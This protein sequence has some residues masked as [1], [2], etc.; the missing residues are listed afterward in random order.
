MCGIYFNSS[1][2]DRGIVE[3]K[4]KSIIYRG[5]DHM[6]IQNL[7]GMTF[8]HL[9]LAILD[10]DS[11]SNQPME[12]QGLHI[13]FNGEIYNFLEIKD[14][15]VAKGYE[16][17]T[18]SDTEVLLAAYKEWGSEMLQ[19]INGMFAF[20]IYDIENNKLFCA[21]DR[22][23]VKPVYYRL[24]DDILEICSQLRPMLLDKK[25]KVNEEAVSI[26]LDCRYIPSPYT[27]I[28]GFYKLASRKFFGVRH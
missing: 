8:G 18:T 9:R 22:L 19:H 5:P 21:R 20:V 26:Y 4:L 16:F 23:G 17:R 28:D 27:I 10:L 7:D 2:L 15:L 12:Y 11:R 1:T 13:V 6:G 3:K 25:V 14:Q 24:K